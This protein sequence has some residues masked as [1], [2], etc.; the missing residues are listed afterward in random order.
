MSHGSAGIEIQALLTGFA[1]NFVRWAAQRVRKR[2]EHSTSRFEMTPGSP[3]RLVQV[4][5]NSPVSELPWRRP[6]VNVGEFWSAQGVVGQAVRVR[7]AMGRR[8]PGDD[9]VQDGR[10]RRAGVAAGDGRRVRDASVNTPSSQSSAIVYA[11]L[12]EPASL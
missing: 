7:G 1:A 4:A 2:V 11:G 9:E 10:E 5:A 12:D 3:K 6:Y 8:V